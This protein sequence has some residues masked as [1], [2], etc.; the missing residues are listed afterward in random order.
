[1]I[2]SAAAKTGGNIALV[3]LDVFEKIALGAVFMHKRRTRFC[4]FNRV[5]DN[6]QFLVVD[7]NQV[8]R[9]RR[10]FL[11]VRSDDSDSVASVTDLVRAQHR[12]VGDEDTVQIS[13]RD[14]FM[15]QDGMHAG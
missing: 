1:M 8:Q 3:H 13:A 15:R 12:P 10:C 4:G 9:C 2:V 14:I 11:T 7:R 5:A 6:G